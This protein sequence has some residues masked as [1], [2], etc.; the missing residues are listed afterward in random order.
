VL[1]P[2]LGA[3]FWPSVSWVRG[4]SVAKFVVFGSQLLIL[5]LFLSDPSTELS[6]SL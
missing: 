5:V 3:K 6:G 4:A 1:A 2:V